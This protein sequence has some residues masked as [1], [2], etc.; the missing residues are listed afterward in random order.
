LVVPLVE[1]VYD[2]AIERLNNL[3]RRT[4]V[5]GILLSGRATVRIVGSTFAEHHDEWACA[6][7]L[8]CRVT[9]TAGGQ[10][11]LAKRPE[12]PGRCGA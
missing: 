2:D 4:D 6:A 5:L 8:P 1:K 7:Q 12:G 3:R 11:D 9:D 10:K